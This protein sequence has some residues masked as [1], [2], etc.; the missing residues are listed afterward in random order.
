[1][2][3]EALQ[4]HVQSNESRLLQS[5]ERMCTGVFDCDKSK[6]AISSGLDSSKSQLTQLQMNDA[7]LVKLFALAKNNRELNGSSQC[8]MSDGVHVL[9]DKYMS[10]QNECVNEDFFSGQL[11]P[12]VSTAIVDVQG[13]DTL[14]A[15]RNKGSG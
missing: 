15:I 7:S 1:M 12:S 11:F 5:D 9:S 4:L 14:L 10:V 2:C 6:Q 3:K 13:R 8:M